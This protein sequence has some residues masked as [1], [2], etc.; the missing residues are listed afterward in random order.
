MVSADGR[1]RKRKVFY[2]MGFDPRGA[3]FYHAL[4]R[5]EGRLSGR[6]GLGHLEADALRQT[7]EHGHACTCRSEDHPDVDIEYEF[8][9]L[10]D[11]IAAFFRAPLLWCLWVGLKM[12]L[13]MFYTGF[14]FRNLRVAPFFALF[15]LYPFVI[16]TL[17]FGISWWAGTWLAG[18]LLPN[19][20]GNWLLFALPLFYGMCALL[21]RH[22]RF[23]YVFYLIGDFYF[24]HAAVTYR[25]PDLQA[26]MAVFAD[27][28][29]EALKQSAEDEE[30]VVAGHSSGALLA[31]QLGAAVSRKVPPGVLP[32]LTV[33]CMGNQA[34]L[35][36]CPGTEPFLED[37]VE[38]ARKV[39]W[40]EVFAPQDIIS[41]GY[42]I[43][44]EQLPVKDPPK[45]PKMKMFSARL[46]RCFDPAKYA[47]HRFKFF[48]VHLQYLRASETGQGF[49]YFALL[50]RPERVE[51]VLH[52]AKIAGW[53]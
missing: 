19:F 53:E 26:R 44:L 45:N 49:N 14:I 6:R 35:G 36:L 5:R 22:D 23:G 18:L 39:S 16:I 52:E 37:I 34:S 2:V 31:I 28:V 9:S 13:A 40:C 3:G 47:R 33:L 41:S 38:L 27:R 30:I 46:L 51:A 12:C 7:W 32:R 8:L 21:R 48:K 1:V 29:A 10:G 43:P 20:A 25:N 15:T 42:F 24:S 50:V 4:L 11:I 17:F